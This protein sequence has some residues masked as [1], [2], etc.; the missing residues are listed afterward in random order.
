M[1][2]NSC[3]IQ[4]CSTMACVESSQLATHIDILD[5]SY[6]KNDLE[7]QQTNKKLLIN[8]CG[9]RKSELKICSGKRK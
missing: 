7:W 1:K 2:V 5:I 8:D 9:A 4:C 6:K 3:I